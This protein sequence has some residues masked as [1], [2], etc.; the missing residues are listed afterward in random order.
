MLL[1]KA[2]FVNP[3]IFQLNLFNLWGLWKW[4]L[5][6]FR[7]PFNPKLNV[8]SVPELSY[9]S[10]MPAQLFLKNRWAIAERVYRL[11][12]FTI[13]YPSIWVAAGL[14]SLVVFVQ[15]TLGLDFE[16]PP[17]LLIF[18][19]ALIPYNLDRIADTYV[20]TIPDQKPQTARSRRQAT[21]YYFSTSPCIANFLEVSSLT[22]DS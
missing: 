2:V 5:P 14:A 11:F 18:A 19:S 13:V 4:A 12:L 16:W 17:V 8:C 3:L 15:Y 10:D 7:P 20:Q 1:P 22:T 21:R 9:T 6:G